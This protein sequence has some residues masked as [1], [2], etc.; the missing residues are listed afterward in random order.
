MLDPPVGGCTDLISEW[1]EQ[2]VLRDIVCYSPDLG[3]CRSPHFALVVLTFLE[4]GKPL[5]SNWSL[6]QSILIDEIQVVF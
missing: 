3:L 6:P 1:N 5:E 2:N 4:D